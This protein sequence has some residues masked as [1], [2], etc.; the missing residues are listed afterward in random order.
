MK[1]QQRRRSG[2]VTCRIPPG[3]EAEVAP[4]FSG[5]SREAEQKHAEDFGDPEI[6]TRIAQYELAY[7]MQ[8]FGAGADGSVER[9][10]RRL[11]LY[12]P[13]ARKP[14]TFAANCILA[15]RLAERGVRFIQL[16]H[17]GWDQHNNADADRRSVPATPISRRRR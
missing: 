11:E 15:R 6:P 9:A 3:I 8:I 12:G 5:R 7:R 1:F 17:R 16:F 10:G 4:P 13:D 14:G 2:A